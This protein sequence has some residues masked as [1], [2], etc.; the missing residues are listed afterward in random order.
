MKK[1]PARRPRKIAFILVS[2]LLL[3]AVVALS[4]SITHKPRALW[5]I[6][7]SVNLHLPP[8]PTASERFDT[9]PP[10]AKLPSESECAARVRRYAWEPR[11]DNAATN[12]RVPTAQQISQLEHWGPAIGVDPKADTLR[13]QITGN[14]TGTTDEIIQWVACKWGIDE[15]I[16]RAEVFAESNWHQNELGDWTTDQSFCPPGTWDG[17]GCYQSYGVLEVKYIYNKTAWPMSRDDTAFNAEY[18]YGIIRTCFEG[19]TTYLSEGTPVAG[20]PRYHAG[21]I[22]GCL[23]RWYS[24]W[25]YTPGAINYINSV[26]SHLANKDWL[27]PGF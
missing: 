9:L 3:I 23:G 11:P 21:D 20:Y 4:V 14:F 24:G 7:A 10:G 16:V 27:Q 13:R 12:H 19:W 8:T 22:W 17:S 15:D 18:T 5:K 1:Y 6:I 2:L 25:W 26:K